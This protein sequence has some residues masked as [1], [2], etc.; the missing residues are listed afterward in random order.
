[1]VIELESGGLTYTAHIIAVIKNYTVTVL[2]R[3]RLRGGRFN[4]ETATWTQK[5][6]R[7]PV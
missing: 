3:K 4:S 5:Y 1:M 6:F 2:L 7:I